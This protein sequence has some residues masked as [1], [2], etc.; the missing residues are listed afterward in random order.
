MTL[1]LGIEKLEKVA[2]SGRLEDVVCNGNN[3][4]FDA[5]RDLQPVEGLED[6]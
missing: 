5:F 2:R 4:V 6:R 1:W 3:F